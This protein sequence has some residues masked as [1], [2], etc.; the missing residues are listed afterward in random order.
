MTAS[1]DE[2]AGQPRVS[3][4][5]V[6]EEFGGVEALTARMDEHE[7]LTARLRSAI[8]SLPE[9][10]GDRWV[11]MGRDEALE[12]GDSLDEVLAR[13]EAKGLADGTVVVEFVSP[14]RS[15]MIL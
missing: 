1:M 2:A 15:A 13:I 12:V 9:F 3:V 5:Q 6:V 10:N 4:A 14:D 7:R 8:A 11:A